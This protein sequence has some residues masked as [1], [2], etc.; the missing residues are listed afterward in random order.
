M[1]VTWTPV[2]NPPI[3]LAT[4]APYTVYDG[5]TL[6]GTTPVNQTLAPGDLFEPSDGP[7]GTGWKV[8]GTYNIVGNTL[9]VKLT[10]KA[11]GYVVADAV[12][13]ERVPTVVTAGA[14]SPG[15]AAVLDQRQLGP[16]TDEAIRSLTRAAR[17]EEDA[18]GVR[19]GLVDL[20]G[21]FL[22][23][24]VRNDRDADHADA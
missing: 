11:N 17:S 24:P 3:T 19:L 14:S 18:A 7:G 21:G 22:N 15:P 23:W 8:L 6:R 20:L 1:A 5:T 2:F 16:A 12:R 13:I 9:V 10:D 4:N